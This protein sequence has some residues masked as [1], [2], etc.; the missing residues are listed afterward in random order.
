MVLHPGNGAFEDRD[1]VAGR[2]RVGKLYDDSD[3][4]EGG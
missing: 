2:R 1:S 3:N 4:P